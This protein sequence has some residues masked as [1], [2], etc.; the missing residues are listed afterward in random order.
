MSESI[1]CNDKECFICGKRDQLHK[2]HI[3]YGT[4]NRELSEEDGCWIYLCG[5]EHNLTKKGVHYNRQFDITL[6]KFC[7]H[8]WEEKYGDR[9]AFRKRYGRSWL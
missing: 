9:E 7:Q 1:I 3:L 8:L 2:H 4:A 6:K 5:A